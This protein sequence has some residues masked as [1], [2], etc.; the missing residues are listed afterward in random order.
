MI[1]VAFLAPVALTLAACGI[2]PTPAVPIPDAE[3]PLTAALVSPNSVL[4]SSQDGLSGASLPSVLQ[5][6]TIQG[7][8][9]YLSRG[10]TLRKVALYVRAELPAGCTQVATLYTCPAS[11]ESAQNIGSVTL[12]PGQPVPFTLQGPALD[13]AAKKGTGYFGVQVLEGQP[14]D[15]ESVRLTNMKA[16][17]R[18]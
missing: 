15:T 10:G 12:T 1:K 3:I 5:G 13:T 16:Q 11:S 9:I 4:Y 6:L 17:A 14:I 8:A 2:V 18:L 7:D